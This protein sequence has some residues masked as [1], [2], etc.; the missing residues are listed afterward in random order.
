MSAD[1]DRNA[2]TVWCAYP[3][4]GLYSR[5]WR[6]LTWALLLMSVLNLH[7]VG[8]PVSA[9][10]VCIAML[11]E[12]L[13]VMDL[14]F[15]TDSHY[16]A[17]SLTLP[18]HLL[19]LMYAL[20]LL[21]LY[22]RRI[23]RNAAA[24]TVISAALHCFAVGCVFVQHVLI[25]A[26]FINF[27]SAQ[28][29]TE[30]DFHRACHNRC[31]DLAKTSKREGAFM[32]PVIWSPTDPELLS[33]FALSNQWVREAAKLAPGIDFLASLPIWYLMLGPV[34]YTVTTNLKISPR[35]ARNNI[36]Q[37]LQESHRP[38]DDGQSRMKYYGR[39]FLLKFRYLKYIIKPISLALQV[40]LAIF[41]T[42]RG[43]MQAQT[44]GKKPLPPLNY[45]VVPRR[46][47]LRHGFGKII[48][49]AWYFWA[50]SL[51][52]LLPFYTLMLIFETE[53]SLGWLPSYGD[54]QPLP[55]WLPMLMIVAELGVAIAP[56]AQRMIKGESRA[57]KYAR[58]N[59]SLPDAGSFFD[60][61]RQSDR[62]L[63]FHHQLLIFAQGEWREFLS[64]WRDPVV[65][66]AADASK[67]I[68][69]GE[70]GGFNIEMS[71][72]APQNPG[73]RAPPSR[74]SRK[75]FSSYD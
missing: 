41:T 63:P 67:G 72:W 3:E 12:S 2:I 38:R 4:S 66:S 61:G 34:F 23:Y 46:S 42:V 27:S 28:L 13:H 24:T 32:A 10:L 33:P 22:S 49:T 37:S 55:S 60:M 52:I 47:S 29:R 44:K 1:A 40:K 16:D 11:V 50:T 48:A 30:C 70:N 57:E 21:L 54:K 62:S 73:Y 14:S 26:L 25:P 65:V 71:G 7:H 15:A 53:L 59:E 64:W 31:G 35:E 75:S 18:A 56:T 39:L 69:E 19:S 9:G 68:E 58:E 17:N 51:Y 8:T 5:P 43:A 6:L 45:V 36:F 74:P 20:L